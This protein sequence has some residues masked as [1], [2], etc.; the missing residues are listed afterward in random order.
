MLV[1]AARALLK[2]CGMPSIYRGDA[3]MDAVHLLNRSLTNALDGKTPY[4]A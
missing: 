3:V 4:E 2:Q 1:A